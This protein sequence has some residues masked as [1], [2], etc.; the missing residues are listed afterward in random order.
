MYSIGLGVPRSL[1]QAYAWWDHAAANGDEKA[2][3]N[4][5]IAIKKMTPAEV[6]KIRELDKIYTARTSKR[7]D[8]PIPLGL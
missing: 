2:R 1:T 4:M 7:P 8:Q 5:E 6:E 3:H